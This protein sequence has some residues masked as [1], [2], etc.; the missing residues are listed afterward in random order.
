MVAMAVMDDGESGFTGPWGAL[1]RSP[2]QAAE[3]GVVY[4][5]PQLAPHVQQWWRKRA[6]SASLDK[7]DRVARRVLRRSAS[8]ARRGGLIT[9]SAFYVGMI[10]AIMMIYCEQLVVVLRIAAVYGRDPM[11][12]IRAAE[13]LVVQGRYATVEEAAQALAR[14]HISPTTK[15]ASAD[16]TVRLLQQ[17]PSMI[18][19]RLRRVNWRSPIDM[20][21]VGAELASYFIPVISL[22]VWAYASARSMRRL[23]RS[24][25]LFYEGPPAEQPTTPVLLPPRP[26]PQYRRMAIASVVPLAV[27]LGALFFYLPLGLIHPGVRWIG[28]ILG[29]AALLLS[30]ARIIRLTRVSV[31][32]D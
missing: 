21:V 16:T 17:L 4:A 30:F 3:I 23:G 28:L 31:P 13:I 32:A 15:T 25:I 6:H 29:E 7:P 1:R 5:L 22:P 12:P 11:D 2:S 26:N 8:V 20:V 9:G 10:P 27:V 24:A 18:G 19:L 14:A